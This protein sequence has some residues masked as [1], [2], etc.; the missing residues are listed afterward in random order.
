MMVKSASDNTAQTENTLDRL[1]RWISPTIANRRRIE[2]I[3]SREIDILERSL[4]ADRMFQ[5]RGGVW[6]STRSTDTWATEWNPSGGDA[7]S[8]DLDD[9]DELRTNSQDLIRT[10][11]LASGA[12]QTKA[13]FSVGTGLEP[14]PRIDREALGLSEDQARALARHVQREWRIFAKNCDIRDKMV[15]AEQQRVLYE[16]RATGGDCFLVR[17]YRT[18]QI[19]PYN[20]KLQMLDAAR[21][22]NPLG[23][24]DSEEIA[25]GIYRDRSGR[26]L[27]INVWNTHPNSDISFDTSSTRIPARGALGLRNYYHYHRVRRIGETRGIP[28]LAYAMEEMKQ[29]KRGNSAELMRW[30][31][32]SMFTAFIKSDSG[33]VALTPMQSAQQRKPQTNNKNPDYV[34]GPA[35]IVGLAANESVDF[36][37][38]DAPN[39]ELNGFVDTMLQQCAGIIELPVEIWKAN[40]QSSYTAARAAFEQFWKSIKLDRMELSR[41]CDTVYEWFWY[42]G[43]SLGRLQAP[44]FLTDPAIRQA[45]LGVEWIGTAKGT[46]DEVKD[47][48]AARAWMD[49]EVKPHST[50]VQEVTGQDPDHVAMKIQQEKEAG[51][52]PTMENQN[53]S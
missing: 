17:R 32:S 8:D 27:G 43:V 49:M 40:Y 42:D 45:Y 29:I 19:S 7:D 16:A 46:I 34:M 18:N 5:A 9:L 3:R 51:T 4:S 38:P 30:V 36:A 33:Q 20:L 28:L 24:P 53:A 10:A 13:V 31:V 41:L 39:S 6:P 35:A 52:Y 14:N 11:P 22:A 21:V 2:R 48:Q 26:E 50:I 37:K 25:G 47:T 1:L 23:V 12:I 44:G 15:F